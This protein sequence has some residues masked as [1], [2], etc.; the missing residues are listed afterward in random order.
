MLKT[1]QFIFIRCNGD[2]IVGDRKPQT[3][4]LEE[5]ERESLFAKQTSH[6]SISMMRTKSKHHHCT[7]SEELYSLCIHWW[8]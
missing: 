4:Q 6:S 1:V 5:R 8:S 3:S 7:L 2:I